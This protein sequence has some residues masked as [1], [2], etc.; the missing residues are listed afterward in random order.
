MDGAVLPFYPGLEGRRHAQRTHI[1][2]GALWKHSKQPQLPFRCCES[3]LCLVRSII[4]TSHGGWKETRDAKI[5]K[6]MAISMLLSWQ[7][8][9]A[10]AS[11]LL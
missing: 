11:Y 1:A 3:Y 9:H 10:L 6:G 7:W 8:G 4:R 5:C 2:H